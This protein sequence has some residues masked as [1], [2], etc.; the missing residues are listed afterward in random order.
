MPQRE[1]EMPEMPEMRRKEWVMVP[2]HFKA[3]IHGDE[4]VGGPFLSHWVALQPITTRDTEVYEQEGRDHLDSNECKQG[5]GH[6][7]NS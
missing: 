3:G 6:L 1:P 4:R 5:C 7:A 2:D